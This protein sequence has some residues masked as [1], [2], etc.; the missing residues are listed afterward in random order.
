MTRS[1]SRFSAVSQ[2]G[3]SLFRR[4]CGTKTPRWQNLVF[5]TQN[6]Q[7]THHKVGIA[8]PSKAIH[9]AIYAKGACPYTHRVADN[10]HTKCA[11]LA[12][13]STWHG[14][15]RTSAVFVF[16]TIRLVQNVWATL[17]RR[18][19]HTS[20]RTTTK[21]APHTQCDGCGLL[22]GDSGR[23]RLRCGRRRWEV[24]CRQCRGKAETCVVLSFKTLRGRKKALRCTVINR[25]S[26]L[27]AGLGRF[28][29]GFRSRP[30]NVSGGFVSGCFVM[31]QDV[32]GRFRVRGE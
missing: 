31:F 12:S 24:C 9:T 15:A 8:R 29:V 11:G 13:L 2:P 10:R 17:C 20:S 3:V 28:G 4:L 30:Y 6:Q 14:C 26:V 5:W 32:S 27:V 21:A 22:Y 16:C 19:L 1:S 7:R 25:L 18:S 23:T